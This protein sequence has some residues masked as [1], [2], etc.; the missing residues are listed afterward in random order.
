M[1]WSVWLVVG[2]LA[3][4]LIDVLTTRQGDAGGFFYGPSGMLAGLNRMLPTGLR[5]GEAAAM[6]GAVFLVMH[7][8]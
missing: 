6:V 2:G 1:P 7:H 8:R 3:V 4:D 5:P